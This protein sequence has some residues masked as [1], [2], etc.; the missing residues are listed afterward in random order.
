MTLNERRP[1][2]KDNLWWK[3]TFNGKQLLTEKF[4]DSALPY[5]AVEDIFFLFERFYSTNVTLVMNTEA[6]L[7]LKKVKPDFPPKSLKQKKI[8]M[9]ILLGQNAEILWEEP[10]D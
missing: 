7:M 5:T 10:Q 6:K 1:L 8:Q 4:W 2:M 9:C 3:T